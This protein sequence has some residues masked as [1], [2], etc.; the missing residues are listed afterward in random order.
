MENHQINLDIKRISDIEQ[1]VTKK[2]YLLIYIYG[3]KN[4]EECPDITYLKLSDE[5]HSL[6]KELVDIFTKSKGLFFFP[7]YYLIKL[8]DPPFNDE[9]CERLSHNFSEMVKWKNSR[10]DVGDPISLDVIENF[11][12][13]IDLLSKTK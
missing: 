6:V 13:Y 1:M 8:N 9:C 7:Q 12:H 10:R 2:P 4:F 11:E 5:Q 3:H